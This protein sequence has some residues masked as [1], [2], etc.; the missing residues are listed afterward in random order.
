MVF[1]INVEVYKGYSNIRNDQI[2]LAPCPP[3]EIWKCHLFPQ[4][5]FADG[6]VF[7][8]VC[9][10]FN[11]MLGIFLEQRMLDEVMFG[12]DKWLTI[13]GIK[14]V[15]EEALLTV[16]QFAALKATLKATCP[17]FNNPISRFQNAQIKKVWQTH[18]VIHFPETIN[19]ETRDGETLSKLFHF[20]KN[21]Y[22]T[23]DFGGKYPDG[24][25]RKSYWAL[26]SKGIIPDSR[27]KNY[28]TI[29]NTL[30]FNGYRVPNMNEAITGI[31]IINFA[32]SQA[33]KGY[34][35]GESHTTTK[36]KYM[37]LWRVIV[38][39]FGV[40]RL[41]S[42]EASYDVGVAGF[43]EVPLR[44]SDNLAALLYS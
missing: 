36:E 35:F 8:R 15:G 6:N 39:A 43:R 27:F 44:H 2:S 25:A 22:H 16:E 31:F 23:Y 33:K 5:D 38:G 30:R 9:K 7:C 3:E 24:P 26:V 4:M 19:N 42:S 1:N 20:L 17:F 29:E 10:T 34:F 14:D 12:K 37:D 11:N 41:A 18:M 28:P 13:P 21:G 40:V 32:Y